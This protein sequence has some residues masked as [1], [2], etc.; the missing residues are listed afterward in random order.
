[1]RDSATKGWRRGAV[2]NS[3]SDVD[4]GDQLNNYYYDKDVGYVNV[5]KFANID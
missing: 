2:V 1:M 5:L 3:L 4:S